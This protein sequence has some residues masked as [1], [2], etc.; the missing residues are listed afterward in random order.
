MYKEFQKF[1]I[2][3]KDIYEKYL[4]ETEG[5]IPSPL[6]LTEIMAWDFIDANYYCERNGYLCILVYTKIRD[7]VVFL[8]PL[9]KYD[10]KTFGE[11]VQWLYALVTKDHRP[12]VF[13]DV[14]K[15]L[16][17][18]M[19]NLKEYDI[20]MMDQ[21]SVS[22]YYYEY[23]DF[24]RSLYKKSSIYSYRHFVKHCNATVEKIQ[25][26]NIECCKSMTMEFYCK[27]HNCKEC[28]YGCELTVMDHVIQNY[29][30]MGLSGIIVYSQGTPVG[31]CMAELYRDVLV[32]HIKKTSRGFRGINEFVHIEL[33]KIFQGKKIKWINYTDDMNIDGLRRYKRNL[34][35][36]ILQPRYRIQLIKRKEVV[37]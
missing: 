22:D 21:D 29:N 36:Y 15:K 23:T 5:E 6:F 16:Q 19:M 7:K 18:Q 27:L 13:L 33:L 2:D 34:S 32:V 1:G 17:E 12:L 25:E 30:Q 35:P 37:Q 3:Q 28:I 10:E 31:F 20:I 14:S 9:G 26:S 8:Q 11:V 4:K 24:Y